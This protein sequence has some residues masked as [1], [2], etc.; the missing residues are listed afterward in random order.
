MSY[1]GV[2]ADLLYFSSVEWLISWN[3]VLVTVEAGPGLEISV[4]TTVVLWLI[5][6]I[7]VRL[8]YSR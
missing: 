4:C 6:E 3:N 1:R 2:I 8:L 7:P 5:Y